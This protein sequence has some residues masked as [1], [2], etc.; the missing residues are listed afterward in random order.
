MPKLKISMSFFH[1]TSTD[2][3]LSQL[4][5][6]VYL[7][8]QANKMARSYWTNTESIQ[9]HIYQKIEGIQGSGGIYDNPKGFI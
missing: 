8:S 1:N 4:Y 5:Q 6:M 2:D 9:N 7:S 3:K